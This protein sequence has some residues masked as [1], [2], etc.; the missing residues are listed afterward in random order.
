[1]RKP[2]ISIL[3]A[4]AFILL[5]SAPALAD[6][7]T[8]RAAARVESAQIRLGDLFDN[9]GEHGD[10]VVAAAPAAG[11]STVFEAPWL[12]VTARAHGLDWHPPSSFTAIRVDRASITIDN[13]RIA[14]RLLDVIANGDPDQRI[15]LDAQ[16]RLYQAVGQSGEIGVESV[17]MNPATGHFSAAV[18]FP[19]DDQSAQL[20]RVSGR[21]EA[22]ANLPVLAHAM[23]PGEQIKASDLTWIKVQAISLA[24]GNLTDPKDIVGR[25]ARHQLRPQAPLRPADIEIPVVI[26]RNELVLIVLERPGLYLTASG[27]ALEDG[28]QGATIHVVNTQSNR[29]ID[30]VVLGAGRVGAQIAG[31]QQAQAY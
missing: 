16:F 26:K 13:A 8:L 5:G 24:P 30:A 17:D 31:V 1:M 6:P 22:M 28:G 27:K 25:S 20:I 11:N 18:R 29:T 14:T 19:A 15:Q 7:A 23:A 12:T 3:G 4:A 21:I 10:D 2:I 9:A